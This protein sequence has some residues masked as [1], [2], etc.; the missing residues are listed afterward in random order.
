ME[1]GLVLSGGMA[2][3]AYQLGALK[4]LGEYISYDNFKYISSSSV[5]VLNAY[6]FAAN[7]LEKA[8][9]MWKKVCNNDNRM[10]V[11]KILRS[12]FLQNAI[13][14]LYA[15]SDIISQ[16]FY[17]TLFHMNNKEVVYKDLGKVAHNQIPRYLKASVAMPIYNRAVKIEDKKYFDGALIDNIPVYPFLKHKL[18]YIICIYFDDCCYKF[19]NTFFDERIIKITFPIKN[20]LTDSV[21]FQQDTIHKMIETGYQTAYY[22]LKGVFANGISDLEYI[23]HYISYLNQQNDEKKLRITGDVLVTNLNKVTQKLTRKKVIV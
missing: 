9:D 21:I 15:P 6:A 23:Y 11:S 17:M 10:F 4:A 13:E 12:S 16:F 22:L 8:E 19:E 3:G 7:K 1:I 20:L 5:G 2:K 14:S 18:D